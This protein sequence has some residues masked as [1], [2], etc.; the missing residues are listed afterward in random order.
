VTFDEDW[1]S[2]MDGEAQQDAVEEDGNAWVEDSPPPP[3]ISKFVIKRPVMSPAASTP[4]TPAKTHNTPVSSSG[5]DVVLRQRSYSAVGSALQDGLQAR[6]FSPQIAVP[7]SVN[8]AVQAVL[9]LMTKSNH[10]KTET[11]AAFDQPVSLKEFK[12]YSKVVKR[13]KCIQD[14]VASIRANVYNSCDDFLRD[15]MLISSNCEAFSRSSYFKYD[16]DL[17]LAGWGLFVKVS[18][19][20]FKHYPSAIDALDTKTWSVQ[21]RALFKIHALDFDH[22]DFIFRV[23]RGNAAYCKV[24][25]QPI[26]LS[27]IQ[28]HTACAAASVASV[29]EKVLLMCSNCRLFCGSPHG[30]EYASLLPKVDRIL[31]VWG[32]LGCSLAVAPSPVVFRIKS[33]A[34]S[35]LAGRSPMSLASDAVKSSDAVLSSSTF[36]STPRTPLPPQSH[37]S[38]SLGYYVERLADEFPDF[39][40]E[41]KFAM[42]PATYR[43]YKQKVKQP[44][45]LSQVRQKLQ[46]GPYSSAQ[47][48]ADVQTIGS[49][50]ILFWDGIDAGLVNLAHAF[51]RKVWRRA[52][53]NA[54]SLSICRVV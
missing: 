20:F 15:V 41:L 53:R 9:H 40:P 29:A 35:S 47:F 30:A 18:G 3:V 48:L 6:A 8:F 26:C 16:E 39:V 2:D 7:P 5:E 38:G 4:A 13:P 37:P 43:T 11:F 1:L 27:E 54:S 34:S 10:L 24:V 25:K 31:E 50:C 45:S 21:Q 52:A 14:I 51:M 12:D 28:M 33:S 46:Q 36:S 23:D 49:N 17:V 22:S 44:M 42:I 19:C 32:G